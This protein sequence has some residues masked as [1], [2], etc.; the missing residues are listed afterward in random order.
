MAQDTKQDEIQLAECMKD[1]V[2]KGYAFLRWL[3][4]LAA[5]AFSISFGV[6]I[7][8]K[9][10]VELMQLAKLA[11]IFNAFGVMTGVVAVHGEAHLATGIKVALVNRIIQKTQGHPQDGNLQYILPSWRKL[12][13]VATYLF[14]FLSLFTW[15][16]FIWRF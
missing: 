8:D 5:G 12:I 14:L 4:L 2:T 1:E 10:P 9:V 13:A 6:L 3:V 11:L 15:I 7:A 16:L